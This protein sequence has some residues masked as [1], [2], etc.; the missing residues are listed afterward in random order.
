[1]ALSF[2]HDG[3]ELF[4]NFVNAGLLR[5]LD[6]MFSMLPRRAGV[7]LGANTKLQGWICKASPILQLA[8]SL[9]GGTAQPVRAILFDKRDAANWALG[10]HQDRT[11]AVR[12]RI[13]V[14]GFSNWTLKASIPHV[15]PP[16]EVLQRMVTARIHLDDVN[17][18][19]GPL[20]IVPGSHRLGR[21][22]DDGVGRAVAAGSTFACLANAGD[23]WLYATPILHASEASRQSTGRRV[24]QIDFSADGLSGGLQWAGM[25]SS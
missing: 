21:L 10:W 8:R 13:E 9:L 25:A 17:A 20:L 11:I 7:R 12:E 3:A 24:L 15:E 1:M 6:A 19:N 22:T 5:K 18:E 16:F 4:P 2:D 14:Q 23:V